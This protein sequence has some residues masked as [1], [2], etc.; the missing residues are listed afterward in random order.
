[1]RKLLL[2]LS[3]IIAFSPNAS[4]AEDPWADAAAAIFSSDFEKLETSVL[5]II[6]GKEI[7]TLTFSNGI[8][9]RRMSLI[10]RNTRT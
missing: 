7:K 8:S 1:M 9:L 10:C 2:L 5:S 6:S 4:F 3:L